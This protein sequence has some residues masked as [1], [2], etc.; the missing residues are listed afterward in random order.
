MDDFEQ[1]HEARD[2]DILLAIVGRLAEWMPVVLNSGNSLPEPAPPSTT[3]AWTGCSSSSTVSASSSTGPVSCTTI[4]P[5]ASTRSPPGMRRQRV[6]SATTTVARSP[7]PHR[8]TSRSVPTAPVCRRSSFPRGLF[9]GGI[10]IF[11]SVRP[12]QQRAVAAGVG[13]LRAAFDGYLPV[14]LLALCQALV[15]VAVCTLAVG[16][17]PAN[18]LGFTPVDTLVVSPSISTLTA[19]MQRGWSMK[20]LHPVPPN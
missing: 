18:V 9:I 11:Q 1:V 14:A 19:R 16:L 20:R 2:R 10:V 13:A 6:Q 5:T 17:R 4:P 3:P 8:T 15:M 12:L 7:R